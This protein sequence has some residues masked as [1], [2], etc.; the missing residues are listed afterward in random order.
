MA[1]RIGGAPRARR[2]GR[3][4]SAASLAALLAGCA[5]NG[6]EARLPPDGCS[7]SQARPANPHGS[8]LVL[9]DAA[10]AAPAGAGDPGE[11]MIFG[12]SAFPAPDAAGEDLGRP[13]SA[14][15]VSKGAAQRKTASARDVLV[16][17]GGGP[18]EFGSC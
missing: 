15:P 2:W 9:P 4:V 10:Q 13:I 6:R 5:A 17:R 12:G 14:T 3:L 11:L 18:A 16:P 1:G 7:R 8:V